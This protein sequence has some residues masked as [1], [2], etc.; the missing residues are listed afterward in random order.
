M[1][2]R[3]KFMGRKQ[4]K[5]EE[6]G[7]LKLSIDGLVES[8]RDHLDPFAEIEELNTELVAQQAIELA[9]KQIE[10]K[11]LLIEI[12]AINKVLGK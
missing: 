10:Y 6:A 11:G 9:E 2:E 5:Q 1:S 12:K 7:K 3:I 4:E 8:I